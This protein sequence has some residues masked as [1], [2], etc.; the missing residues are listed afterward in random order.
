MNLPAKA[1]TLPTWRHLLARLGRELLRRVVAD[2]LPPTVRRA[3]RLQ[4]QL[5]HAS[6][7]PAMVPAPAGRRVLVLA[8]HADDESLGCGGTLALAAQAGC[9]VRVLVLT[10]GRKGYDPARLPP[11]DEAARIGFEQALAAQRLQE[12]TAACRCLGLPAPGCLGMPDGALDS[13]IGWALDPLSEL[14]AD[15]RPELIFAPF[16]TDAHPDHMAAA[17]LLARALARVLARHQLPA[18][19]Q[20]WAYETWT[21]LP[22]NTF[23]DIGASMAAKR[24]AIAAHASQMEGT[25]YLRVFEGLAAYRSLGAGRPGGQVEAFHRDTPAGYI[26]QVRRASSG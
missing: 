25:D 1:T 15:W 23:V 6:Q 5:A 9:S 26:D 4:L 19:A 18:D 10:D 21:P 24:A 12:A 16:A 2:G 20:V 8:P 22:A 11:G 7:Q 17:R 3:L 14:L 13:A